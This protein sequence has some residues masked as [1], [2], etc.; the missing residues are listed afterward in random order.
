MPS[1][2]AVELKTRPFCFPAWV[3]W[4]ALAAAMLALAW[5]TLQ[6]MALRTD[7]VT[8]RTELRL[9]EL[10][11]KDAQQLR[12]A[13]HILWQHQLATLPQPPVVAPSSAASS[14]NPMP[15]RA[16]SALLKLVL[17]ASPRAGSPP[18]L[19]AVAWNPATHQGIFA[20][21]N[22]P[23]PA[24]GQVY[25]LWTVDPQHPRPVT[26]GV[27][28]VDPQTGAARG[29]FN[30]VQPLPAAVKFLVSLERQDGGPAPEGP[31]VLVSP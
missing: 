24:P 17:L 31:V 3:P 27:I 23:P 9:A 15:D 30:P 6:W 22:L 19:A 21:Q 20:A 2:P 18:A 16:N 4:T 11:L 7:Q 5:A 29:P 13:D 28:D 8:L 25:R 14:G 26:A 12:E 1:E 10:S